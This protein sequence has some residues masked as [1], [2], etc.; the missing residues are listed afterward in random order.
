MNIIVA[1]KQK[2]LK[3]LKT[4]VKALVKVSLLFEEVGCD[5]VSISFVSEK[6]ICRLHEEFFNDPSPTDCI[7]FPMDDEPD[8]TYHILG[9]I[10]VCPK[11]AINYAHEHGFNP[12]DEMALYIIHGLLHLSGYD[13]L[14]SKERKK[15]R[16]AEKHHLDYIRSQNIFLDPQAC[17][18]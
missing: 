3:I 8:E 1:N 13:D 10:F 2:D 5:E 17:N 6:E 16:L 9:E 7:S 12:Y 14:D 11:T 15:M 18:R 4:R